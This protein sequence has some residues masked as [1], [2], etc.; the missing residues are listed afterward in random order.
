MRQLATVVEI[1]DIVE[2]DNADNLE[3]LSIK[4]WQCIAQKGI[5]T[6][7]DKVVYFEIDSWI[8]HVVAP[9]L[10][11]GDDTPKE[12]EGVLGQRLRTI[13]LRKKLSQGM[14]MPMSEIKRIYPDALVEDYEAGEDLTDMLGI[15]KWERTIPACLTGQVAGAFPSNLVPK[16]DQERI[17]NCFD[18]IEQDDL[19]EVTIKLDGSSCTIIKYED[20]VRVCSRNLELKINEENAHNTFVQMAM[21]LG[22][23]IPD[24][25]A[26]QGE[27]MGPGIQGNRE[28]LRQ[29]NWFV[30]DIYNIA[31]KRYLTASERTSI[32][33]TSSIDVVPLLGVLRTPVTLEKGL[34]FAEGKSINHAVREGVVYK[35]LKDP[36]KSFKIISN[37]FLLKQK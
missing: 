25:Y 4:G 3:I 6:K 34:E 11:R 37:K 28:K 9:F 18:E 33:D 29:H 20:V 13:R 31:E 7:G 35:N 12:Y 36:S 22:D 30:F 17:Q 5:H 24:G 14:V 21:K 15:L 23:Q 27:M 1:K 2:H 10:T 26:L 8:P 19:W 16:T 32:L